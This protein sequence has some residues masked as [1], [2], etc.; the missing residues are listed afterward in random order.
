MRFGHEA[1]RASHR[2]VGMGQQV[3]E[4]KQAGTRRPSRF[5]RIENG[6]HLGFAASDPCCRSL[7]VQGALVHEANH[8]VAYTGCHC[9]DLEHG[10]PRAA[11]LGW[12]DV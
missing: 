5:Q 9:T 2:D 4:P 8:L 7:V 1:H 11:T 3:A 6:A 12:Q 10:A